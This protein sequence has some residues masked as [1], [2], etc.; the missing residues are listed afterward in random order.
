MKA[1]IACPDPETGIGEICLAGENIMMGYCSDPEGAS[2]VLKDGWLY[3]GD[4]GKLDEKGCL[5]IAGRKENAILAE[6]GKSVYPEE[7]ENYLRRIP[8]VLDSLVWRNNPGDGKDSGDGK[9]PVITATIFADEKNV[10]EKLGAGYS[11][12]ELKK[13]LWG[14]IDR[15]NEQLPSFQRIEKIVLRKE[16]FQKTSCQRI[17]RWYPANRES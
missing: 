9:A 5:Y 12:Q 2:E 13:L 6:N 16:A 3:T 15:L 14:E 11:E 1:K 10:T 17:I 4:L 7:L 8:Y